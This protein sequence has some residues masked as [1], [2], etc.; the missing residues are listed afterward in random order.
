VWIAERL[1][2]GTALFNRPR[3]FRIRGPLDAAVLARAL[4]A[5]IERHAVLRSRYVAPNGEVRQRVAT[6]GVPQ[7]PVVEVRAPGGGDA[8]IA[9]TRILDADARTPFRLRSEGP[10]RATIFRL[11]PHDHAVS[12]C[13]HHIAMDGWSD[14]ILLR[15]TGALYDASLRADRSPLPPL[16][17]QYADF[18]WWQRERV[19]RGALDAAVTWWRHELQGAPPVLALP[20]DHAR[21]DGAS[22]GARAATRLPTAIASALATLA[23]QERAT[24]AIALLAVLQRLVAEAARVDD[25]V[26]G[27]P[28]AARTHAAMEPL[29]GCFANTL[30]VRTDLSGA[31]SFREQLG[32]A[33][34]AS[35]AAYERQEVPFLLLLDALAVPRAVHVAPIMQVM[36]NVRNTP[37]ATL[38]LAGAEVEPIHAHT[39]RAIVDLALEITPAAGGLDCVMEYD[40]TLFRAGTVERLL[41]R[42]VEIAAEAVGEAQC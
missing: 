29:I 36:L 35:V 7:I 11:G 34:R 12:I 30:P 15:E 21:L 28:V 16:A 14:A 13:T 18:A 24:L 23:Q 37:P 39:A 26:I 31:P 41:E 22:V 2:P 4:G 1:T 10:I 9:A 38:T 33:R 25:V 20:I 32:R 40:A 3:A 42:F 8:I 6:P 5:V 17:L 19:A 27:V